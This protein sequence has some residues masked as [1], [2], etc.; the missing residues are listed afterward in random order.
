MRILVTGASGFVGA[1]L[2]ADFAQSGHDVVGIWHENKSRLPVTLPANLTYQQIDLADTAAVSELMRE[3]GRLDGVVHTAAVL[4]SR[5]DPNY[6]NQAGR[7][8]VL[9]QANLITAAQANACPRFVFTSTIGVYGG[10]GAPEGGY[11]EED[12]APTTYYGWCK[13]AAEQLSDV[14][15]LEGRL[16][17]V[18][19]RLAGVHGLGRSRGALYAMTRA[20]LDGKPIT[21]TEPES[22][23]RWAFI[24]D[25]S[26]A[27]QLSLDSTL[28]T[29]HHVLNI[30]SADVFSLGDLAQRI[31]QLAGS[32]SSIEAKSGAQSRC[33]VMNV[34]RARSLLGFEPTSL[35]IFLPGYIDALPTS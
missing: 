13:R 8:N 9:A 27:V 18:S 5:L 24:D 14:A 30:A 4:D 29:G 16:T 1:R 23:F 7:V 3:V 32:D 19:L 25:V 34:E 31:K 2:T 12:T 15:S 17:A 28:E 6:L 11:R 35:D 33:E 20:A 10:H 21:V 22:H 26:R